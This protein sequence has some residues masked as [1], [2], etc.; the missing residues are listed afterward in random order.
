MIPSEEYK[1]KMSKATTGEKNGNFGKSMSEE[2][3]QKLRELWSGDKGYWSGKVGPRLGQEVSVETR[4]KLSEAGK[5]RTHSEETKAKMRHPHK[6]K[7]KTRLEDHL[8]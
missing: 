7:T 5:R 8:L 2:N 4:K 1:K 3:K 6:K